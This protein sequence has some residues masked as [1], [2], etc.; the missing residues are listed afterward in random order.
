MPANDP[1]SDPF[2]PQLI[3]QAFATLMDDLHRHLVESGHDD[4]RPTHYLNVFRFMDCDGTRPTTLA[5]RA[6]MTPQAMGE[7][8][9]YL[10]RHD[11]VRRVPDPTD[12]RSRVVVYADRGTQ[13]AETATKYFADLESRWVEVVGKGRLT[14]VKSALA[15]IVGMP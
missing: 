9:T 5:R 1:S 7:L 6:G 11:Y 14:T 8:V 4:L 3:A 2:L 12:G 15:Q 10:E 13:A